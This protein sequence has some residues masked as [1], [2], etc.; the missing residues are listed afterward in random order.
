MDLIRS[1]ITLDI[2]GQLTKSGL[3]RS[4]RRYEY[5]GEVLEVLVPLGKTSGALESLDLPSHWG[6]VLQF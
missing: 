1:F 4:T 3:E 6:D 2:D 5:E